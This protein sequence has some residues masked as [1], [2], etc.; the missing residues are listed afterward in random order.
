MEQE[1]DRLGKNCEG[2]ILEK[3][4]SYKPAASGIE[5]D[6]CQS[7]TTM[8]EVR[9]NKEESTSR[10]SNTEDAPRGAKEVSQD[11]VLNVANAKAKHPDSLQARK[12]W[13]RVD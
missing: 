4:R 2:C 11:K 1:L 3:R 12:S 10:H 6:P 5:L 8:S 7:T 13:S 9:K